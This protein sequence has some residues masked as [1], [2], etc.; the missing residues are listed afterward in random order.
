LLDG[1]TVFLPRPEDA[2]NPAVAELPFVLDAPR[3]EA[4]AHE[5]EKRLTLAKTE[6]YRN[7]TS[8]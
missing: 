3:E 5:V 6:R 2:N 4:T 7:R 8:W 1:E